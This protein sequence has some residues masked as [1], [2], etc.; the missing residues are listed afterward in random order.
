MESRKEWAARIRAE[1]AARTPEQIAADE[2]WYREWVA[3]LPVLPPPPTRPGEVQAI[4]I[5]RKPKR[6]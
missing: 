2:A 4:F 5:K 1:K 3:S 6:E